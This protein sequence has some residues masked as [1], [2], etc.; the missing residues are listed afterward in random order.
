MP[1]RGSL[2]HNMTLQEDVAAA[3]RT[4]KTVPQEKESFTPIGFLCRD[5][6][7]DD[8]HIAQD[9][10]GTRTGNITPA[11]PVFSTDVGPNV[12]WVGGHYVR[13]GGIKKTSA[14][15]TQRLLNAAVSLSPPV[16]RVN[17]DICDPVRLGEQ[18]PGRPV[19]GPVGRQRYTKDVSPL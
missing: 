15:E 6:E 14:E 4:K 8:G 19:G 12:K 1:T 9:P 2:L 18:A 10:I 11:R 5:S 16:L 13:V 7:P 3:G 17:S